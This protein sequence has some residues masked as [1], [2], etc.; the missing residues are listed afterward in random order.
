M[1]RRSEEPYATH[2]PVLLGVASVIKPR[3]L[4]EFGSGAFSTL[5]FLDSSAFPSLE[6]VESYENNKEW[7]E[8]IQAEL[9]ATSRIR[10]HFVQG[11]MHGAVGGASTSN[12][13]MIFIDDSPSAE[14][15]VESVLE[16]ARC[17]GTEPVVVL[18]DYEL[19]KLRLA[20]RR[21]PNRLSF[22]AFNPQCGVLW[23]GHGERR[24]ALKRAGSIIRRF[25]G[26]IPP[27]DIQAWRKVF[28]TED[29]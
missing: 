10:L 25:A 11:D 16:I 9:P 1:A 24:H 13:S 20:A 26:S 14:E 12:A 23:H 18:H 7:L 28:S 5:S 6:R 29:Y 2:I 4:I 21:F 19:W 22:N 17:C 8:Q 3:L 15:R 27:T